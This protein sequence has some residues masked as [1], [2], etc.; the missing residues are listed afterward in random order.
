MGINLASDNSSSNRGTSGKGDKR[1]LP[2]AD[3]WA[4]LG[5]DE[6]DEQTGE[7]MFVSIGGVPL[8]MPKEDY[9]GNSKLVAAQQKLLKRLCEAGAAGLQPGEDDEVFHLTVRLRRP[10]VG[11]PAVATDSAISKRIEQVKL[12]RQA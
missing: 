10:T 4:N 5:V 8:T 1:D 2:P 7:V 12:G 11:G 9:T 6:V 3:F